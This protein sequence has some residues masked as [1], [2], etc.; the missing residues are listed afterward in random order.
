MVQASDIADEV[1]LAE[2]LALSMRLDPPW[3]SWH[4]PHPVSLWDLQARLDAYPPKVVLA[5]LLSLLKRGLI[6]GCGCGCR[7]DFKVVP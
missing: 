1:I 3:Q 6:D 2:I 4:L 5:K 7:G